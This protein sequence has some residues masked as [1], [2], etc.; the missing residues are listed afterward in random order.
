[1]TV[2]AADVTWRKR[3]EAEL[4]RQNEQLADADRRKDEFLATLAHEL[5]NPLAPI[6]NALHLMREPAGGGH[7][8]ERAMAERQVVHLARLIDDLMDVARISR[9]QIELQKRVVD[10]HTVVRQAVETARTQIDD[11]RH[12]LSVTLPEGPIRLEADPTRLEQV[13]WNLLNNAAKYTEPGGRID[14]TAEQE[15]GEVVIRV[16]DTGIGIDPEML[17]RLFQMF[18]Q[19]GE[20]REH[21]QGGL[22]IGLGLVRTLVEL[23]GGTITAHSEGG[24]PAASSS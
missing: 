19:V 7:E 15:A 23:H 6:R 5:R 21:A 13:F 9:G 22:G 20:H 17:P 11:R 10:L 2:F 14:L 12:R 18:V 24:A 1:V 16:R 8:E 3:L 4:R